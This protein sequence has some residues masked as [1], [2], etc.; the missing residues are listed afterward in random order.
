MKLTTKELTV[1]ELIKEKQNEEGH[2]DFLSYDAKSKSVGGVVASLEKK[3]MVYNSYSDWT[4]KD[5][6]DMSQKPFKMWCLTEE[7]RNKTARSITKH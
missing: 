7:G 1:L 6:K 2:S 3:G 5:F 4:K